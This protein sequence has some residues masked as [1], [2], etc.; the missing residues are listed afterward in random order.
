MHNV[1]V[2]TTK[3]FL[4]KGIPN[5]KLP[6]CNVGILFDVYILSSNFSNFRF[7]VY[8][9]ISVKNSRTGTRTR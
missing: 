6:G 4:P 7:R 9:A 8:S 2:G 5:V 1:V 3:A